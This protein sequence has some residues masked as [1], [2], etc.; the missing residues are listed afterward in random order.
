MRGTSGSAIRPRPCSQALQL[1]DLGFVIAVEG[2]QL[3]GCV[4]S[5][6]LLSLPQAV[7]CKRLFV[8][9]DFR[10]RDLAARLMDAAEA[11]GR[12]SGAQW[13]YLDSKADFTTAIALYRRRGYTDCARFNDNA[14]ATVF[15]RKRL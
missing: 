15:L 7:E 14:Q 6:P 10:G 2:E 8:A 5:R 9:P 11:L 1:Q 4:L 3:A 13:M 12:R